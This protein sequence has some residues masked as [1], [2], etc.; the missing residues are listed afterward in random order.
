[1]NVLV[2]G[3][4]AFLGRN[5]VRAAT[6]RGDAVTTFNRGQTGPDVPGV[7]VIRGDRTSDADLARLAGRRWDVVVDTSGY[8][9]EV[10]GRSARAL[11]DCGAYVFVSSISACRDWPGQPVDH[12]SPTFDCPPDA[13]SDDG[14]YGT[15]KAGCERAVVDV[16]G[17]RAL[18]VR[19]GL[20]LGPYENVGRL[21][22]WLERIARGGQVLA[23][24]D[25]NVAMTLVDARDLAVW[26]I[27]AGEH[28]IGGAYIATGSVGNTTMGGWLGECVSA[29]GSAAELMWV[30]DSFL[31]D[32]KV[33]PWT[34]LPLWL[35][36]DDPDG[37]AA[38][39]AD[40]SAAH[41][42]GLSCR[43]VAETVADTWGWLRSGDVNVPRR[44]GIGIDPDK[45]RAI[46][47]DWLG[48]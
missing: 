4:T 31:R 34:E 16:Y 10:V 42:A 1:M 26:M 18:I 13:G 7:E 19:A 21:P 39:T 32:R 41:A 2:L 40:A 12:T 45:E 23:P 33:E 36:A 15:L 20:I 28:G 46:L 5:T 24:G 6:A 29:T 14:D 30:P 3:G 43:S 25:P 9:P 47:A 8:V 22:W 17:E 27:E 11:A 44:D 48:R 37:A 38:W 35:D